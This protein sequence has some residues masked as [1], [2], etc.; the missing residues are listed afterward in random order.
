MMDQTN[1]PHPSSNSV[2]VNNPYAATS[3]DLNISRTD[4]QE[5]ADRGIRLVATILDVLIYFGFSM[6]VTS[7]V[8]M[9]GITVFA[10]G[11]DKSSIAGILTFIGML[12]IL[13]GLAFVVVQL[14]FM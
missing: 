11:M 8:F 14:V 6:V 13:P 7:I 9:L 3:Q 2:S 5:L 1:L 4:K 12:L 10:P